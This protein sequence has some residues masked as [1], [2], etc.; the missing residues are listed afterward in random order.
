M[1]ASNILASHMHGTRCFPQLYV[2]VFTIL[3]HVDT[4]NYLSVV[5]YFCT[6]ETALV[7]TLDDVDVRKLNGLPYG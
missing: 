3:Y 6:D 2:G 4:C 7:N 1:N 5:A